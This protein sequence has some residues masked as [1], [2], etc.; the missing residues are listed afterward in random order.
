M[1]FDG[2]FQYT[3]ELGTRNSLG[4]CELNLCDVQ[5]LVWFLLFARRNDKSKSP[6]SLS[7]GN[8]PYLLNQSARTVEW[9]F[10]LWTHD[11]DPDALDII[12]RLAVHFFLF[13]C[14]HILP[15]HHLFSLPITWIETDSLFSSNEYFKCFTHVS[16][17]SESI[18]VLFRLPAD[19]RI[20]HEFV[21]TY[22]VAT[23]RWTKWTYSPSLPIQSNLYAHKKKLS[24]LL[25]SKKNASGSCLIYKNVSKLQYLRVRS[26]F[27]IY[28]VTWR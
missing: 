20:L 13:C 23:N 8:L 28:T 6:F 24:K 10:A 15:F 5:V 22:F 21:D 27:Q 9:L 2:R 18:S 14:C 7:R 12:D 4:L 3:S 11:P 19:T 25:C 17:T 1:Q 16:K 26:S